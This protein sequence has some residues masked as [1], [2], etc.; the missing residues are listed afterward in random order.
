M[1]FRAFLLEMA[2]SEIMN[3]VST[4]QYMRIK[5]SDPKPVF[6]AYVVGHEG[7]STGT[8]AAFGQKLGSVV[9]KWYQAAIRKLHDKIDVG[10]KLFHSH[11][12]TN[13]HI[14]RETIGEVVGRALKTIDDKLSVVIAAYIQPQ[15]RNLPLDV[16]S[17]EANIYLTDNDGVYEADVETVSGIALG[18]SRVETPG[19]A[20]ATLLGQVQAFAEK[21]QKINFGENK[22][23]TLEELKKAIQEGKFK[24]S[25][26]FDSDGIFADPVIKEQ[27]TERIKNARGYDNRKYEELIDERTKMQD[28]IK[29]HETTIGKLQAETAKS[30]VGGL[31][32]KMKEKRGLDEKEIKFIEKKLSKFEPK[33]IDKIEP[34]LNKYVD[35][36]VDEFTEI[37]TDVFEEKIEGGENGDKGKT[38]TGDDKGKETITSA[39]KEDPNAKSPFDTNPLI[40]D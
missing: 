16:A 6:R 35:D 38:K 26:L 29:E 19:F 30:Q 17:I 13:E 22:T 25:D 33:E 12:D 15:F 37:R 2:E 40:P 1:K 28:K 9:K 34:E 23:M 4:A 20:G 24:P 32:E 8:V 39:R 36:L 11:V 5:L 31:F 21:S 3:M 27:V 18:S 10:L 14:G 7:Q